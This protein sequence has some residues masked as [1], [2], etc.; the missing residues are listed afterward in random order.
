M[1]SCFTG[2]VGYKLTAYGV[3]GEYVDMLCAHFIRWVITEGFDL[4]A[5][6]VDG[7]VP[8][9]T[10]TGSPVGVPNGENEASSPAY[11]PTQTQIWN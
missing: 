7:A 8:F 10:G 1:V 9:D 11:D 2:D 4:S 5:L 3:D 6:S